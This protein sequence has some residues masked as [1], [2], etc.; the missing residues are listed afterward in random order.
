MDRVL[1]TCNT[2]KCVFLCKF[3]WAGALLTDRFCW[4]SPCYSTTIWCML[5]PVSIWRQTIG[6]MRAFSVQGAKEGH[7]FWFAENKVTGAGYLYVFV[8]SLSW[9]KCVLY[10]AFFMKVTR[11]SARS[12]FGF[13]YWLYCIMLAV[14]MCSIDFLV[15]FNN[16][17]RKI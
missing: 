10:S 2:L 13:H 12:W 5:L 8:E 14:W 9:P 4:W 7:L 11:F 6:L 1:W 3:V 17:K 15:Y 16:C